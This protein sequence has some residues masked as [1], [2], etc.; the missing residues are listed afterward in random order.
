MRSG[1]MTAL[2]VL[3]RHTNLS[4]GILFRKAGS[5]ALVLQGRS[6]NPQISPIH[7]DFVFETVLIFV[8]GTEW[9]KPHA[10]GRRPERP[11]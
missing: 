7:A 11:P 3:R 9:D 6:I 4:T 10:Q 5:Y 8:I 1:P 2:Q